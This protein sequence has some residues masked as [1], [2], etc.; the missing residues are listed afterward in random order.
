[1][2][3]LLL[4]IYRL[5]YTWIGVFGTFRIRAATCMR[6]WINKSTVLGV[7]NPESSHMLSWGA[8]PMKFFNNPDGGFGYAGFND[9]VHG[10]VLIFT[11]DPGIIP[12]LKH[13]ISEVVQWLPVQLFHGIAE[14]SPCDVW[15]MRFAVFWGNWQLLHVLLVSV[16]IWPQYHTYMVAKS[17]HMRF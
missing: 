6:N 17:C 13:E 8:T 16:C 7:I 12:S 10:L 4:F 3:I 2:P 9:A 15:N 1:M 14:F 5:N 11:T